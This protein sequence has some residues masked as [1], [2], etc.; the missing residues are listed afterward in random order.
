MARTLISAQI[1]TITA[2]T[3]D[4][5]QIRFPKPEGFNYVA[6][7]FIQLAVPGVSSSDPKEV[8]EILR[9]YSLSSYTGE[10]ELELCV[11]LLPDGVGSN[12]VREA[13]PGDQINFYGP[14]GRFVIPNEV[15]SPQ[16]FVATGVGLAPIMGMIQDGLLMRQAQEPFHLLFGVRKEVDL[17]WL[18]RLQALAIKFP[19]F[20]YTIT[21]SQP[22]STWTGQSGRVTAHLDT[23]PLNGQYYLCGSSEM[24]AE[25]K[26]HLVSKGVLP[27]AIHLEIF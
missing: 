6:G 3:P 20:T 24:V 16:V 27:K 18:D 15:T 19:N 7:Q 13:R 12:F 26:Q 21:L 1:S 9:S 23:L 14:V 17:F 10:S 4:V 2:L 8:I 5:F 11:K 25:V 22:D